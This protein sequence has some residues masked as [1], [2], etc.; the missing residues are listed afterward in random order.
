MAYARDRPL[1]G[2]RF[3][4]FLEE[5]VH[6]DTPP[7]VRPRPGPAS[8]AEITNPMGIIFSGIRSRAGS[9]LGGVAQAATV[10]GAATARGAAW[11]FFSLLGF[12]R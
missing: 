11:R 10:V 12:P 3:F 1:G 9:Q 5:G 4:F 2:A 7:F 6:E 8:A